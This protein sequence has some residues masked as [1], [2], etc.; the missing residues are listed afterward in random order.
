MTN[1]N[2]GTMELSTQEFTALNTKLFSYTGAK[3]K[4]KKHFDELHTSFGKKIKVKTYIEGFAGTL[5]SLFHNLMHVEAQRYV[6]ND[7]NKRIINIYKHVKE[8]PDQLF[9][10]LEALENEFQRIIPEEMRA[11]RYASEEEK[12]GSFK[13]NQEFYQEAVNLMNT[14]PLDIN[15]AALML[16]VM[17]HNYRGL[18]QENKQGEFNTHFN[19]ETKRINLK[20]I[21]DNLY[22]LHRFFNTHD[23]VF[24]SLDVFR[25]VEKYDE[26]DTFIYLD[27]PYS[28]SVIQYKK[29]ARSFNALDT[30]KELIQICKQFDYVMY[31]NNFDETLC[32]YFE[33]HTIFQRG[34]IK[35]NSKLSTKEILGIKC[36]LRAY[37]P[38]VELLGIEAIS[39]APINNSIDKSF[40]TDIRV[41]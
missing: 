2:Q 22:N 29:V 28:N 12:K 17:Q 41:A 40:A 9:K 32:Q 38:I 10:K 3:F 24:E 39:H 16:F 7:F 13:H 20:Q 8:S 1:M 27:P 19:W 25:L 34:T 11:N 35:E 18:Y 15:H 37:T 23:V 5:A 30:H 14:I 6:I 26:Q 31:S 36:N 21:K 33:A 4:F